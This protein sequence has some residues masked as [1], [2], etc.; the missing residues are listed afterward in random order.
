MFGT[1][2]RRKEGAIK[3]LFAVRLLHMQVIGLGLRGI[4]GG[5]PQSCHV[6]CFASAGR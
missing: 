6:L 3:A 4:K 5:A 1:I 2:D